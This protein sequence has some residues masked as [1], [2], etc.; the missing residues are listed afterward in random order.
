MIKIKPTSLLLRRYF[1]PLSKYMNPDG[2]PVS[3]VFKPRV[4]DQ[5]KLSVDLKEYTCYENAVS[6]Y[7]RFFLCEV[8]NTV[9]LEIGLNTIHDPL[10]DGSNDAH[11]LVETFEEEDDIKPGLLAR[12]SR[13]IKT[14]LDF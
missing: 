10:E 7:E 2:T 1:T 4:K 13:I 6:D 8:S 14:K 11:A 3:R 12:N 9:V 5:G